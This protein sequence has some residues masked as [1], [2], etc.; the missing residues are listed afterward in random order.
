MLKKG[1][2]Q[3]MYHN[4]LLR[5][6]EIWLCIALSAET[7]Y[8]VECLGN[9]SIH[10]WLWELA[11]ECSHELDIRMES[12]NGMATWVKWDREQW[13]RNHLSLLQGNNSVASTIKW[14]EQVSG[15]TQMFWDYKSEYDMLTITW[16]DSRGL[17]ARKFSPFETWL[18]R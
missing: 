18:V 4:V 1:D 6:W 14:N 17:E 7:I 3:Y 15:D 8:Y 11:L 2:S 12:P 5:I 13:I 10:I 9:V 16:I